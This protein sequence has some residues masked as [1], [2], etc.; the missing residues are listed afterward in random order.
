M[1]VVPDRGSPTTNTGSS[2]SNPKPL[3][4]WKNSGVQ[5]MVIRV[6]KDS[7][8][9][10]V[11]LL[12][13]PAPIRQLQR[14]AQGAMLGGLGIFAPRVQD[15][16]QAESQRYS[17]GVGQRPRLAG[18]RT[19]LQQPT[20]RG[21]VLLRKPAAQDLGQCPMRGDEAGIALQ[22]G[23]E[24]R[25]C[26]LKITHLLLND[27]QIVVRPGIIGL[28][29]QRPLPAGDRVVELSLFLEGSAQVVMR[30]DVVRLQ[31]QCPA[32]ADDRFLQLPLVPQGDAQ[33]VVR[34]GIIR[35]QLQRLL[36]AGDR[37]GNSAQG[38]IRQ[39]QVVVE[40]RH[41]PIQ[42]DGPSYVFNGNFVFSR[43]RSN[44]AQKMERIGM[45]RLGRE[46]LPVDLLGSLQPA[47]LM[48][49]DRAYQ[50]FGNCCHGYN[51]YDIAHNADVI[52][53]G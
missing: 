23:A 8:R 39:P 37:L 31:L 50:G 5:T 10:R 47:G 48:V 9:L 3:T 26:C 1:S 30:I 29:F 13:A 51:L 27:A 20:L 44:H 36:V 16:G 21:Q 32:A 24:R 43:L 18:G 52:I 7:C 19:L 25:F 38:G 14:V 12:P 49:P 53:R 15:L 45:I 22:G 4:R 35:F 11:V 34:L 46:N 28:H 2:L 6:T 40:G 33:V 41:V 17:L 42:P